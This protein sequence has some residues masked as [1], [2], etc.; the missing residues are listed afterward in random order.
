MPFQL[1]SYRFI[2]WS[3]SAAAL[4]LLAGTSA[5]VAQTIPPTFTASPFS[6]EFVIVGNQNGVGVQY[7]PAN[8]D[9]TFGAPTDVPGLSWVFGVDVADSDGDGDL[10][11]F[12]ADG[13][14][15][16]VYLYENHGNGTFTPERVAAVKVSVQ[17]TTSL[18]IA[19]F[20]EDGRPDFV[21]G[22][23]FVAGGIQ[24]FLQNPAGR[25]RRG[26]RLDLAWHDGP[27]TTS[28]DDSPILFGIAV[29]DIDG[30]GHA[31]IVLLGQEG[32]G[33]GEVRLY[34]G[35]GKGRFGDPELI[36]DIEDVLGVNVHATGLA[37][38]DLEGDGDLDLAIGDATGRILVYANTGTGAFTAPAGPA[39]LV[40]DM[41]GIDAYDADGDGDHDLM[42]HT[43]NGRTL[44]FVEN[45][46]GTL[47][48]PVVVA[49]I[50]GLGIA[51]GAPPV[52]GR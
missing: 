19:D 12:A 23:A 42:I 29:G 37:A 21:I 40:E 49:T 31:D 3:L 16:D 11:F 34:R 41:S 51:V 18:R 17:G 27:S 9:G 13:L 52:P 10:D 7:V 24:V 8:G 33:G 5:T 26:D 36:F 44:H 38:F 30:D 4:S 47:S 46:G 43:L 22:D 45:A 35:N 14:T 48:A 39:V 1:N 2:T 32:E 25:F 50:A 15:G 20:N 28:S 6:S